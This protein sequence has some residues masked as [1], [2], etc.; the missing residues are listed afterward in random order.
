MAVVIQASAQTLDQN[1][2]P[3]QVFN[4][5]K[6]SDQE[7]FEDPSSWDKATHYYLR[8]YKKHGHKKFFISWNWAGALLTTIWLAFRKM[9]F[10]C[11]LAFFAILT[12]E[13]ILAYCKEIYLNTPK[14]INLQGQ[15]ETNE[16]YL[17]L[18]IM[19]ILIT[20][21]GL[22]SNMIYFKHIRH[23]LRAGKNYKAGTSYKA[24]IWVLIISIIS[25]V[26]IG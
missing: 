7:N 16:R 20:F 3:E 19:F 24:V 10:V 23:C 1:L 5:V 14:Y 22:F 12:P 11:S 13:V 8:Q 17:S 4:F 25:S 26:F 18:G 6:K 21:F 15:I 9:Y 2:T